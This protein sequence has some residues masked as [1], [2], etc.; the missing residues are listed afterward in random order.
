VLEVV[1][2]FPLCISGGV[3]SQHT[4]AYSPREYKVSTPRALTRNVF[5][6]RGSY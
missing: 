6:L 4:T 1:H 3:L 5:N 2:S